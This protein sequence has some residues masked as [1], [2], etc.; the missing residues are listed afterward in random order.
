MNVLLSKILIKSKIV[1][2]T[3]EKKNLLKNMCA[4]VPMNL[5]SFEN[6]K[7]LK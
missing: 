6:S 7:D 3:V 4:L 1:D 5:D 2:N